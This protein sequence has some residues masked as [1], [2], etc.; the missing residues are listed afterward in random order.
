MKFIKDNFVVWGFIL[1]LALIAIIFSPK[2]GLFKQSTPSNSSGKVQVSTSFYPL[3]YFSSQ[4]GGDKAQV[5][6]IT[7]SG[8]EPH[9]YDPS[10]QDIA[11]I[12]K[13]NI[14]VLNGAVESWGN[15]IKDNLK[16]TNVLVITGGEGLENR[17]LT[18]DGQT[19]TD[20]HIWLDPQLAKK[21]VEKINQGFDKIDPV[22]ASYYDSNAKNL[23]DRL[24]QLDQTYKQG[25][26][27]C[28]QKDIIT[29]HA[30]FGYMGA[31]YGLNQVAIAGLSPDAEPSSQQLADVANFARQHNVKYIFF[32]S[33]VSPKLSD[34][35]A[36]E[37]GA[38]TMVLDP[39]EGISDDDIKQGK[40][41]FTVMADNLKNLQTALQCK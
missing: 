11:H 40:D 33:L 9:D 18:E 32:E 39:I 6:N 30:A 41:Y 13:A 2:T 14:L 25:L 29:S 8:T 15:K 34:T 28:Q 7:P 19:S 22:N 24:D 4:I 23:A 21:E 1:A 31:R 37:V 20:P 38:K 3:Y 16:G 27:S 10:T 26:A 12:E 35:I 17:Q 36:N 5:M